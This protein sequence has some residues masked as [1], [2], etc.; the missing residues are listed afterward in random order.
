MITATTSV[1]AKVD[2]AVQDSKFTTKLFELL[3]A[4]STKFEGVTGITT[5]ESWQQQM[6]FCNGG[7]GGGGYPWSPGGGDDGES[8]P[9]SAAAVIFSFLAAFVFI[10]AY[11]HF[12]AKKRAAALGR[13]TGIRDSESGEDGIELRSNGAA[14]V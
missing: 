6:A 3:S 4:S 10:G 11:M 8:G 7:G 1:A 13:Y 2:D 12:K 14:V 5:L 9:S